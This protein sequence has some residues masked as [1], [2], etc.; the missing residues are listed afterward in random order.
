[1]GLL[2]KALEY[3]SRINSR[4]EK[5]VMDSIQGPADTAFP[6]EES[7]PNV[8]FEMDSNTGGGGNAADGRDQIEWDLVTLERE[9]LD[10]LSDEKIAELGVGEDEFVT[11]EIIEPLPDIIP[12]SRAGSGAG[13]AA[14]EIEEDFMYP[15]EL[16][17]E[18]G[19]TEQG[20]AG[21]E[22][23]ETDSDTPRREGPPA[24][25]FSIERN[26]SSFQ[27]YM[28]LYEIS[29]EIVRSESREQLFDTIMFSVMGQIGVSSSSILV[30]ESEGSEKWV[31]ADCMGVTIDDENMYFLASE[32]ILAHILDQK[33]II[34]LE[35]I[36]NT[37]EFKDDYYNYVSIDARMMVPLLYNGEVMAIFLL[38]EKITGEEITGED[39]D[40]L[41]S[42]AEFS[43]YMLKSLQEKNKTEKEIEPLKYIRD[44][45]S[46]YNRIKQDVSLEKAKDLIRET[47]AGLSIESYA[48]F[49]RSRNSSKFDPVI[50]EE[51][52]FLSLRESN[53]S[54]HSGNSLVRFLS[55]SGQRVRIDDFRTSR[56]I[57]DAFS[58]VQVSRMRVCHIYPFRMGLNLFG[59]IILFKI[60]DEDRIHEI[61]IK[62]ER[63]SS[64]IFSYISS[65]Q[66]IN[67]R[68]N[69]YIDNVDFI[70]RRIEEE[71]ANAGN[72]S[73]P[74][75]LVLFSIKN[76][77]RYYT[78]YGFEKSE[79]LL[80]SFEEV[81]KNRL[82]EGDFSVRYDRHKILLVL[83]GKDK[84]YAV[85]MANAIRNDLIGAFSTRDMQLLITFLTAEY[86]ADGTDSYSLVD[87]I[88]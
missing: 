60:I 69:R 4:G 17:E 1:M 75:T 19:R 53:F 68:E 55:E 16:S 34:D 14:P 12:D 72:L 47:M 44:I 61:D 5:T 30:P 67:T 46:L 65:L 40:F 36:K 38:G 78:V 27:D 15:S 28:V 26:G 37:R 80:N 86:P 25:R 54:L 43:S 2:E 82:S 29:K 35:G 31:L 79:E 83:P 45:D 32:G 85:P 51:E 59:F 20:S 18:S 22:L 66:F 77:K 11:G 56:T 87:V 58:D 42:V 84:R 3:K 63:L 9:D 71:I 23:D 76:F 21:A 33:K 70:Y 7:S 64:I 81:I 73:I 10:E 24:P 57:R 50:T 48:F 49:I 62:M 13:E 88:D 41:L 52:D 39:R 6:K 74:L 8:V